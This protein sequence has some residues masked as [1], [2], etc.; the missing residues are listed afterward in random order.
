MTVTH[1]TELMR[2]SVCSKCS[3]T[4]YIFNNSNC[5]CTDSIFNNMNCSISDNTGVD[6]QVTCGPN[7][8]VIAENCD[9]FSDLYAFTPN[10]NNFNIAHL[11]VRSLLPKIDQ[12]RYILDTKKI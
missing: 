8:C 12:V 1:D 3:C 2:L 9:N 5:S 4:E 11:N 10:M 6:C 7:D